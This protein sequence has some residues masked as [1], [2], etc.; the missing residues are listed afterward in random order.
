MDFTGAVFLTY[1]FAPVDRYFDT[2]PLPETEEVFNTVFEEGWRPTSDP[3]LNVIIGFFHVI[4]CVLFIVAVL[5]V[6]ALL[7]AFVIII[8]IGYGIFSLIKVSGTAR[9]LSYLGSG[10][11][12]GA[13]LYGT[14]FPLL[15]RILRP[16]LASTIGE[17]FYQK[18]L[19]TVHGENKIRLRQPIYLTVAI[20]MVG[21]GIWRLTYPIGK[22]VTAL[23]LRSVI[24]ELEEEEAE[25]KAREKQKLSMGRRTVVSI[26]IPRGMTLYLYEEPSLDSKRI[27]QVKGKI[28]LSSLRKYDSWYLVE[29]R[30]KMGWLPVGISRRR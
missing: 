16:I 23:N 22:K 18:H 7:I 13:F 24:A 14:I 12:I 19:A 20:I 2:H 15:Y 26:P 30:G 25:K 8:A 27:I 10:Y 3:L 21:L 1:I 11:L 4:G 5:L 17:F 28:T 29:Y 9:I 6:C